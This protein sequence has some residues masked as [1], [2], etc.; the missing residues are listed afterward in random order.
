VKTRFSARAK[1]P[2]EQQQRLAA[3]GS[4]QT[5]DPDA[6]PVE[7]VAAKKTQYAPLGLSGDTKAKK[8]QKKEK[9]AAKTRYSDKTPAKTEQQPNPQT[10]PSVENGQPQQPSGSGQPS[11]SPTPAQTQ[12]PQ[13][14]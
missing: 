3:V 11:P 4:D 8:K 12:P 5:A 10:T 14:E 13:N 9:G 2:K 6:P 1:L 7:E